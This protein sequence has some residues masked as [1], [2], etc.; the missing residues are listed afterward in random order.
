MYF[1]DINKFSINFNTVRPDNYT[2]L[3]LVL[4]SAHQDKKLKLIC[5]LKIIYT[6]KPSKV[7]ARKLKIYTRYTKSEG[8]FIS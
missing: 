4:P 1:V 3:H 8:R 5:G 2:V 6:Y 7:H